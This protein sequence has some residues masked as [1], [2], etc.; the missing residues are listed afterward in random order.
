M[1]LPDLEVWQAKLVFSVY[2]E[3]TYSVVFTPCPRPGNLPL[4]P[5]FPG[6]LTFRT[7]WVWLQGISVGDGEEMSLCLLPS[8]CRAWLG[9]GLVP[10]LAVAAPVC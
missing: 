4:E 5:H 6:S 7:C 9:S 3:C 2:R 10:L 1:L 8:S